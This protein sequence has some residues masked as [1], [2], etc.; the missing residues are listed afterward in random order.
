MNRYHDQMDELRFTEEQ[1]ARMVERLLRP[2][3]PRRSFPV[4]REAPR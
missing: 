1:K 2:E 4:R 3:R